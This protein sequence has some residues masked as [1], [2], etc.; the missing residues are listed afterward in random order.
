MLDAGW[1][2]SE[3]LA[4]LARELEHVLGETAEVAVSTDA[5]ARLVHVN[6][7]PTIT[8]A[9][10]LSWTEFGSEVVLT[11]GNGGR[12]ELQSSEAEDLDLLQS[13]VDAVVAG[14]V[15]EVRALGRSSVAVVL[16]DGRKLRTSVRDLPHGCVPLPFWRWWGARVNFD[17]YGS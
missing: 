7:H 13:I 12:W 16:K 2:P 14:R 3:R 4:T 17:S 15:D 5:S 8:T 1:N 11:F 6:V 10:E 9:A